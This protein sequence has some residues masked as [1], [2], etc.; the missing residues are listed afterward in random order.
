VLIRPAELSDAVAVAQV[1]VRTWQIAYRGLIPDDYLDGLRP[2]DQA[3]RYTFG[4]LGPDRPHTVL[5]VDDDDH[6]VIAGF[7]TTGPSRDVDGDGFGELYALYVDP[8]RW[9]GGVGGA[10]MAAARDRLGA[11]GFSEA[12]LWVLAGNDRA[13]RFYRAD[14]WHADGVERRDD[15]RGASVDEIRFLTSLR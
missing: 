2:E 8:D 11:D 3:A 14:G 6:D 5:A 13:Q 1:H 12:F 10:L 9:N 15:L 7:A 4:Q